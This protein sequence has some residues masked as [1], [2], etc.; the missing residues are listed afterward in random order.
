MTKTAF[1]IPGLPSRGLETNK[2]PS[3]PD[4]TAARKFRKTRTASRTKTGARMPITTMTASPIQPTVV[5]IS[6]KIMTDISIRTDARIRTTTTT[7]FRIRLTNARRL[8]KI[9][10][11]S[12]MLTDV[13]MLITTWMEFRI[14]LINALMY[15]GSEPPMGALPGSR[16]THS[17]KQAQSRRSSA[18]D[19]LCFRALR[20]N[21][22]KLS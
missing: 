11:D 22:I 2:R 15:P 20:L 21:R 18:A 6:R 1:V 8:P 16:P 5:P 14:L 12:V 10:T 13:R 7:V 4:R 9:S 17:C 3:A 19:A